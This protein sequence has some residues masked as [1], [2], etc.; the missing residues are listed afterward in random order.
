MASPGSEVHRP[1]ATATAVL[2]PRVGEAAPPITLKL[3]VAGGRAVGKSTFIGSV[4]DSRPLST[5]VAMTSRG[6]GPDDAGAAG[7]RRPTTLAMD[8]GRI[9]L[10]G[11]LLLYLFG[12]P[13]QDP[14]A[15]M[16]D[17]LVRGALGAVV[18]VDTSR[19]DACFPAVDHFE[20]RQIPYVVAVNC[21]DGQALHTLDAVRG[22]L[23][24]SA[25]V[26]VIHS[27]ARDRE[28]TKQALIAVVRLAMARLAA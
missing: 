26:P 24:V 2:S 9:E 17:D 13:A 4:S 5:E 23:A 10:P 14:F 11:N 22:A 20:A 28:A 15:L 21:F 8:F 3:L 19:L 25:D 12:T 7:D 16:S 6:G 27:D 1:A 18:L